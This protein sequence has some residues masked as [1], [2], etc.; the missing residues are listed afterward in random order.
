[1]AAVY[2]AFYGCLNRWWYV[3][4]NRRLNAGPDGPLLGLT[5]LELSAGQLHVAAPEGSLTLDLSAIRR[6]EESE[7]H[8][9]I[10]LGPVSGIIVPKSGTRGADPVTFIASL[11]QKLA[12]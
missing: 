11:Q 1:M 5:K 3:R 7:S 6:I 10:Y 9:F 2:L 8:Y 12:A 4:H